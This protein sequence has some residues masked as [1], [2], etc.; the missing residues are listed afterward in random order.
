MTLDDF[1]D[2]LENV[3][4][5]G[6]GFVAVCPGHDDNAQ[7]LGI[8]EGDD[9][10]V[11]L[12]CY[13]GCQTSHVV[14]AMGL[15]LSDLF[16]RS[17]VGDRTP[18]EI[19]PYLD[20][21]GETLFEALRYGTGSG[22]TFRQRH[23]DPDHP[24]AKADGYVY[25]LEGVRRVPFRLPELLDAV[26]NGK[27]IYVVEGEKDA[28]RIT[29]ETGRFATCNP[30]G[31]LKWRDE[32]TSHFIG[33][34]QVFIIQDNDDPGRRHAAKVA[35]QMKKIGV[36]VQTWK[37]KVGKD[38]SEHFDAG[39]K[40][41]EL[42]R[43]RI[44]PRRGIVTAKEMAETGMEYLQYRPQDM[45][46]WELLPGVEASRAVPGRLA[47]WGAYTG[48]GKTTGALQGARTVCT[49]GESVG[50]F[51]MEMSERDLRNRLIAHH[52][53]PMHLLE[54]PWELRNHPEML[55][56]YK[57][58]LE[59]IAEWKLDIIYDTS[60]KIERIIEETLDREYAFVVLDHFHR[61]THRDRN[62]MEEQIKGLTNLAL[63]SNIPILIL[64]QL[65]KFTRGKDMVAYPPP[66]LQDFRETSVLGDEASIA[67]A[68]WRQRDQEGLR[69]IGTQS[70]FRVLKN[71]HTT[72]RK[73][74]AGHVEILDFND[75]TQKFTPGGISSAITEDEPQQ[76]GETLDPTADEWD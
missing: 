73:D 41:E 61:M 42:V 53:V 40:M 6:N 71:R 3:K 32:Y 34:K 56:L 24:D 8:T 67:A 33:A 75:V 21:R 22:K 68:L 39:H 28:L 13:A 65:R 29:Q 17:G 47:V 27:T 70:Q 66:I 9:G 52:G 19:Y 1:L 38:I 49:L 16:A 26:R 11:L 76:V 55:A 4:P 50:Y 44:A 43:P 74:K 63:D 10:R 2:K 54:K 45:P 57:A 51:S 69:Y 46:S 58:A 5:A 15:R 36:P 20:E 64:A 30:M 18:D 62:G 23:F 35:E 12:Q 14:E 25:S 37:T 60:L 48:D 31:A 59:E 72:G 7:S